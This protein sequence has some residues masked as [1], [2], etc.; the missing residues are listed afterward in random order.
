MK[1]V[2]GVI[3]G[4]LVGYQLG[5]S[6]ESLTSSA[7]RLGQS[8]VNRARSGIQTRLARDGEAAF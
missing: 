6:G 1:F 8:A 5:R 3:V 7:G 2:I 4:F